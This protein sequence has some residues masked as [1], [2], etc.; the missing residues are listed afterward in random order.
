MGMGM[1]TG[2]VD[3]VDNKGMGGI[4]NQIQVLASIMHQ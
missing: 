1:G 3:K 2:M 4:Y